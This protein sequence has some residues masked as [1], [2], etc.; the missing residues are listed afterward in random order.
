M[1]TARFEQHC[2]LLAPRSS[3][4][5]RIPIFGLTP[6]ERTVLAFRR[7]GVREFILAGDPG[8]VA[9]ARATLRT[10]PCR[11]V[12]IRT[13]EGPLPVL[14]GG[15][16]FWIAR[17]D[18]HY[19]RRLIVR[20][21]ESASQACGSVAAVD[22]RR[23]AVAS[24]PG[25]ANVALWSRGAV[26]ARS[27]GATGA[28]R[29]TGRGLMSPDGVL[30]GL[31][32]GTATLA[33]AL[34]ELAPDPRGLERA[35]AQVAERE[36][37][38]T[39][40]VAELWQELETEA[41]VTLARRKVL[42]GAVGFSDGV[43]ARHLNRPISRRI[44]ER[45]LSR[46]VKP[47]QVSITVFLLS[48]AAGVGF[49]VGHAATGG[50][51]AQ[52]ASVLD[53]VDGELAL[54]RYQD[55]PFGGVYDALL[56]RVGDAV[57]IGGMT[58]YAWLAGAGDVAVALGFVAVAGSSLSMLVKEKYGTQFQRTYTDDRE[59]LFRWLLLG[60]DGRL[61]LALVAGVTGQVVPVLAYLAIG[62]HLHAGLRIYRIRTE[63]IGA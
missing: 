37:V 9:A 56:D 21:V 29:K 15:E 14:R 5:E 12:R 40:G 43:V 59:G 25:A 33:R 13:C 6:V 50:C 16:R 41:D 60:R 26:N 20:F 36:L 7:A 31:A 4:A 46:N 42:A 55:S 30:T 47:W 38:E 35:L 48:L 22:L 45:L 28:L 57:V 10:G 8:A 2:L 1:E 17:T 58:L 18:C 34:E 11:A 23:D 39:F 24:H 3:G 54:V 49:A 51:L 27:T 52:L 19:D 62:T 32:V 44:T 53:G 63:A 61:F